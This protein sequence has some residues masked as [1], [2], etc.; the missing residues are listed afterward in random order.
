MEGFYTLL[1]TTR[2]THGSD[3]HLPRTDEQILQEIRSKGHEEF[4]R[5]VIRDVQWC[6]T[7]LKNVRTTSWI[8]SL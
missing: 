3:L 2:T 7:G 1:R 4:K 8:N 5:R 6:L